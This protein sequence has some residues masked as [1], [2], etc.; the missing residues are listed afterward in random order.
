MFSIPNLSG[1]IGFLSIVFN[2]NI[3]GEVI[4]EKRAKYIEYDKLGM[5][6]GH[7]FHIIG[8]KKGY[9]HHYDAIAIN[10]ELNQSFLNL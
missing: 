1:R 3:S 8:S 6:A 9:R 5:K 10:K 7:H 4:G 2:M